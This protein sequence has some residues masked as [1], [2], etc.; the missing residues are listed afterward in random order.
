MVPMT[1]PMPDFADTLPLA[2][3]DLAGFGGAALIVSAT[4]AVRHGNEQGASLMAELS[5]DTII[6]ISAAA[7]RAMA[8]DAMRLERLNGPFPGECARSEERRVGKECVP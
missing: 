3:T 2:K 6:E 1:Q 4:G 5:D 7:A 8:A